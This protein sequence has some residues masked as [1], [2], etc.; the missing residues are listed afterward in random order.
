M[1][2]VVNCSKN[3]KEGGCGGSNQAVEPLRTAS[4][5]SRLAPFSAVLRS[6]RRAVQA[7]NSDLLNFVS[8]KKGKFILPLAVGAECRRTPFRRSFSARSI[9]QVPMPQSVQADATPRQS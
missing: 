3:K 1:R 4:D 9:Q 5:E 2:G 6:V 8:T 7:K